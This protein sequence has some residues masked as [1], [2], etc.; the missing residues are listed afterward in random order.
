MSTE[1]TRDQAKIAKKKIFINCLQTLSPDAFNVIADHF[2]FKPDVDVR[3][4]DIEYIFERGLPLLN[5]D[6]VVCE[7]GKHQDYTELSDAKLV[8]IRKRTATIVAGTPK[9][10]NGSL[11]V[12]VIDIKNESIHYFFIPKS[13]WEQFVSDVN[14]E[15]RRLLTIYKDT[16]SNMFLKNKS[17]VLLTGSEYECSN[18]EELANRK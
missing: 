14:T 5:P 7:Y 10:K 16:K 11:R 13:V 17:G 3:A 6:L 2:G 18:I 1:M 15:N 9:L 4:L 8:S 12:C